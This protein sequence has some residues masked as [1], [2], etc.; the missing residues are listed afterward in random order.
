MGRVELGTRA[1]PGLSLAAAAHPAIHRCPSHTQI[2]E[3]IPL[4]I[5]PEV[6]MPPP[7]TGASTLQGRGRLETRR[8][9]KGNRSSSFLPPWHLSFVQTAYHLSSHPI[10]L[11][12][13]LVDL[14]DIS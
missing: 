9:K 4:S 7:R 2:H 11:A 3:L 14:L 6:V 1:W 8:D 12:E 10:N 13:P 5:C